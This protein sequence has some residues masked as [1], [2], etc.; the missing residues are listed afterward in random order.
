MRSHAHSLVPRVTADLITAAAEL[1]Q[2]DRMPI[3]ARC[4]LVQ[5]IAEGSAVV[6]YLTVGE[7]IQLARQA[8]REPET[9]GVAA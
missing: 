9:S 4:R 6:D 7:L 2:I 5:L 1:A 3:R 8:R